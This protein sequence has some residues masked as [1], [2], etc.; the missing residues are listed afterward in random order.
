MNT[1]FDISEYLCLGDLTENRPK[2]QGDPKS[3]EKSDA[4]SDEY[5]FCPF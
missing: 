2:S 5:F 3:K 1:E 4:E